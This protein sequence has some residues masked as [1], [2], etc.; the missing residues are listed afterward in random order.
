MRLI[1][2][3]SPRLSD[4][5][6]RVSLIQRGI[7]KLRVQILKITLSILNRPTQITVRILDIDC[8]ITGLQTL[9]GGVLL[10]ITILFER[11]FNTFNPSH[12]RSHR[13]GDT[14]KN[15]WQ[16]NRRLRELHNRRINRRQ[17]RRQL[18]QQ[19]QTR[20]LQIKNKTL[21]NLSGHILIL[22][23]NL[24]DL[25]SGIQHPKPDINRV[26]L[27]RLLRSHTLGD[28][29][30]SVRLNINRDRPSQRLITPQLNLK[31]LLKLLQRRNNKNRRLCDH[32]LRHKNHLN[33]I[34]LFCFLRRSALALRDRSI[35]SSCLE[36]TRSRLALAA[37]FTGLG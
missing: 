4:T 8:R 3:L 23:A 2:S 5:N 25:L 12:H 28:K 20:N 16:Q 17:T 18:R 7:P 34:Q 30:F 27:K 21:F 24:S 9:L 37:G 32:I 33:Y 15:T 19:R 29:L 36:I 6:N 10:R 22:V 11:I 14:S 13:R 31:L 35:A 1:R 26:R